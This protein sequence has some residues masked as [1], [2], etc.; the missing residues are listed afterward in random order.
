MQTL[1]GCEVSY[2]INSAFASVSIPR[3]K[4]PEDRGI[5]RAILAQSQLKTQFPKAWSTAVSTGRGPT[6]QSPT[7][8]SRMGRDRHSSLQRPHTAVNPKKLGIWLWQSW[9]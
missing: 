8:F 1:A 6:L 3:S 9:L 2:K 7:A 5:Q 4:L